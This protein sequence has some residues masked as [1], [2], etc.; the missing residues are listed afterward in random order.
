MDVAAAAAVALG[1][2]GND[3]ASAALRSALADA[4]AEV[5]SAVAEGCVLCAERLHSEGKSADAIAIYDEVRAADVPPQRIIEATR[6]A[7]LAR[8]EDGIPLLVEQLHSTDRGLFRLALGTAREFPGTE[9][10]KVLADRSWRSLRTI[11]QR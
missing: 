8:G 5:R 6:G 11:E 9:I 4:A 3:D 10:D 1:R 2:I 7:I